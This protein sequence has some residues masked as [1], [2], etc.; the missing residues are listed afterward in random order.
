MSSVLFMCQN[1]QTLRISF[2]ISSLMYDKI[3]TLKVSVQ[4]VRSSEEPA[5]KHNQESITFLQIPA[6]SPMRNI[7]TGWCN[8]KQ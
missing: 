1:K 2:T 8:E 4:L 7:D 3:R 6:Q 5:L